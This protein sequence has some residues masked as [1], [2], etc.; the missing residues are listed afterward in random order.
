MKLIDLIKYKCG[1]EIEEYRAIDEIATEWQ[2]IARALNIK[3]AKIT[4]F[5]HKNSAND[6]LK[7]WLRSNTKATWAQL[8][9]AMKVKEDLTVAAETLQFALNNII[10]DN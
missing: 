9:D 6:M 5:E 10:D 1:S 2:A 7:Y 4:Q 8:I 3:E